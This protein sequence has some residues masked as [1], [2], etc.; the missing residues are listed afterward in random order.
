MSD[1]SIYGFEP[2]LGDPYTLAQSRG[3]PDEKKE[4]LLEF[5]A[6]HPLFKNFGTSQNMGGPCTRIQIWGDSHSSYPD[7]DIIIVKGHDIGV[8]DLGPKKRGALRKLRTVLR[9]FHRSTGI[10]ITLI[11][12][13]E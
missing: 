11:P 5:I 9:R 10:E 12:L 1:I 3:L 13:K 4:E 7:L 2:S 6:R 8:C